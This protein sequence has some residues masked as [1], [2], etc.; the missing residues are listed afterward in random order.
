M[1]ADCLGKNSKNKVFAFVCFQEKN[2][3]SLLTGLPYFF[4]PHPPPK[5]VKWCRACFP[6]C[7][8]S[9]LFCFCF[10][11]FQRCLI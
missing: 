7:F 10:L 8:P 5:R 2:V 6:F 3:V 11:L 4:R 9:F 1:S